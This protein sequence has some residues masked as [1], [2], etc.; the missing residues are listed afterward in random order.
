MYRFNAKPLLVGLGLGVLLFAI[1]FFLLKA[2]LFFLVLG[3]AFRMLSYVRHGSRSRRGRF[4]PYGLAWHPAFADTIRSMSDEDYG[5]FRQQLA[6]EPYRAS[7][8][9][10][11]Q[12]IEIQ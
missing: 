3:A 8:R 6:D 12:T 2:L 4:A 9:M 5:T 10:P 1:P 11:Q 7:S